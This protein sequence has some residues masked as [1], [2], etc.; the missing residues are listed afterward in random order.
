MNYQRFAVERINY[1]IRHSNVYL[2]QVRSNQ[3]V[4]SV[5]RLRVNLRRLRNALWMFRGLLPE[6][7]LSAWKKDMRV[8]AQISSP[9]RD[10]DVYTGYLRQYERLLTGLAA[11]EA[12]N[13]L[14]REVRHRRRNLL[15][16]LRKA[17]DLITHKKVFEGMAQGLKGFSQKT[18]RGGTTNIY[19]I[20]RKRILKRARNLLALDAIA[21]QSSNVQGLHQMRIASKRLRYSLEAVQEIYGRGINSYIRGVLRFHRLLGQIHDYDVWLAEY[22]TSH[23]VHAKD[24]SVLKRLQQYTR[25]SRGKVYREFIR[26]WSRAQ[27]DKF[28]KDLMEYVDSPKTP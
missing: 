20:Y 23:R 6:R 28:F 8:I 17:L 24:K 13:R 1:Y 9:I 19:R 27:Q 25:I 26:H 21:Y 4:A 12:L 2:R 3:G 15:P 16:R 11:K 5:H 14:I 18:S 10:L 7:R 22:L